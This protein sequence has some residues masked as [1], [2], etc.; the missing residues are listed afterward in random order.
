MITRYNDYIN[1]DTEP[2][3]EKINF[4]IKKLLSLAKEKMSE[5]TKSVVHNSVTADN[6]PVKIGG[7]Y[8]AVFYLASEPEFQRVGKIK[9]DT[10]VEKKKSGTEKTYKVFKYKK[11]SIDSPLQDSQLRDYKLL[12][13]EK[14]EDKLSVGEITGYY[15]YKE[16]IKNNQIPEIIKRY[17]YGKKEETKSK[18]DI[19]PGKIYDITNNKGDR[20]ELTVYNVDK[21]I[22]SGYDSKNKQKYDN[23]KLK[24]IKDAALVGDV[25]DKYEKQL[26]SLY[27]DSWKNE[28]EYK[29]IKKVEDRIKFI[30]KKREE[31]K[32][33]K[34]KM[35]RFGHHE[36]L[37]R[38]KKRADGVNQNM[39]KKIEK[40]K[41]P[42]AVKTKKKETTEDTDPNP[43]EK[44]DTNVADKDEQKT[45]DDMKKGEETAKSVQAQP[46]K[47]MRRKKAIKQKV[48]A[49]QK[50]AQEVKE[51][52]KELVQTESKKYK[53]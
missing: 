46:E 18:V 3:N 6:Q 15:L 47:K 50:P 23:F 8:Y 1:K 35:N 36:G 16:E 25:Y 52:E 48:S 20:V 26:K 21:G 28:P 37:D 32:D 17:G 44:P 13:S 7:D 2:V 4:S 10:I 40:L 38:L 14:S 9:I 53:E 49:E 34:D 33:L 29:N 12:V 30:E 27:I 31:L 42:E 45:V 43:T 11:R 5:V 41:N 51:E 24:N 39:N 19:L 22:V